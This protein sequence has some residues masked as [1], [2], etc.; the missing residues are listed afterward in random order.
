VK[1]PSERATFQLS[2]ASLTIEDALKTMIL[3]IVR[4]YGRDSRFLLPADRRPPR[5]WSLAH[6]VVRLLRLYRKLEKHGLVPA[7]GYDEFRG[8]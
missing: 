1:F 2:D 8:E 3:E 7:G 5:P 4:I 6:G